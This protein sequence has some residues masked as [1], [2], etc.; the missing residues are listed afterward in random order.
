MHSTVDVTA[1]DSCI[2]VGTLVNLTCAVNG[3]PPLDIHLENANMTIIDTY[4]EL[5]QI[6]PMKVFPFKVVEPGVNQFACVVTDST[7]HQERSPFVNITGLGRSI[8][9]VSSSVCL[10]K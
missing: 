4:T 7:G 3:T 9:R 10:F 1:D 8:C 5:E 2:M 6:N